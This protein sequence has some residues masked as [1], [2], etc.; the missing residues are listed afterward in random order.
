[1]SDPLISNFD[2][3]LGRNLAGC[4]GCGK[5]EPTLADSAF[6][7]FWKPR[8]EHGVRNI[9]ADSSGSGDTGGSGSEDQ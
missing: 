4:S 1:M 6:D 3:L 8:E 9:K 5:V 2:A 7:Q